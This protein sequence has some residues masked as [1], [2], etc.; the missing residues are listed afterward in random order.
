[1]WASMQAQQVVV[2]CTRRTVMAPPSMVCLAAL[3]QQQGLVGAGLGVR[4][5]AWQLQQPPCSSSWT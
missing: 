2:S 3:Q 4:Q 1:M 5:A